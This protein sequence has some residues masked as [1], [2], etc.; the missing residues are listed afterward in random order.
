MVFSFAAVLLAALYLGWQPAMAAMITGAVLSVMLVPSVKALPGPVLSYL[1]T[2]AAL[3]GIAEAFRRA[4]SDARQSQER[5]RAFI[6]NSV[7]GIYRIEFQ[8][9][10][11]TTLPENEVIRL[12]YEHGRLAECNEAFARMYGHASCEDIHGAGLDVMLPRSDPRSIEWVRTI[13]RAGYRIHDAESV[14]RDKHGNEVWVS[15]T[16]EGHL[17]DGRLVRVWG[18]Q[19]ELSERRR[20]EA[21]LRREQAFLRSTIDASP[22]LIFVKDYEGRF[23]LVNSALA[24]LY[25]STPEEMVGKTDADFNPSAEELENFKRADQRVITTLE[26]LAIPE[27]PVTSAGGD[28]RWFSTVKVPLIEPDGS[29]SRVLGVASDITARK[30]AEEQLRKSEERFRAVFNQQY[31]FMAILDPEGRVID[32]NDLPLRVAGGDR[33]DIVGRPFWDTIWWRDLPEERAQWRARL[34]EA[35]ATDG[36]V[37]RADRYQTGSGEIRLA[38]AAIT[39]IKDASGAVEF[40]IVQA[41]DTTDRREAERNLQESEERFRTLADNMSQFCWM[42]DASGWIFWYNRRWYEYTGTTL[43]E[44]QGWGWRSVHHPDHVDRVVAHYQ[45]AFAA[46]EDWEDTFPLRSASGEYRWFLSRAVP[47]RDERGQITR[48]FGTNTDIT[49]QMRTQEELERLTDD[50]RHANADLLQF[51]SIASHDLK[52]PLRGIAH[53]AAFV[54]EDERDRLGP[55]TVQRLE[56]M[57]TLCTRLSEMVDGL[58]LYSRTGLEA[59]MQP[60]PLDEVVAHVIDTCAEDLASQNASVVI[61]GSLPV[62]NGDRLLLERVFANLIANGIKFNESAEKRVEVSAAD[63]AVLVRDNGI[64]IEPRHHETIF[65]VFRR[66]NPVDKYAGTGL[67]LAL[68]KRIVERHGGRVELESAPGRGSTFRLYFPSATPAAAA[69]DERSLAAPGA[70]SRFRADAFQ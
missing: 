1:F 16:L 35:A 6:A 3:I 10:V 51:A 47:I 44:V 23:V 20:S 60:C 30:K 31:Q 66:A 14:E 15:N 24:D 7:E 12:C 48:W 36:P 56:R 13:I 65:R 8:P 37:F 46:G 39:A 50:L 40:Y 28:L 45:E 25:G 64:G 59:H 61:R 9:P 19:R 4:A 27:E 55:A 54:Q 21:A 52:E 68:V 5:Y 26:P 18:A 69:Q 22:S 42:A 38:D 33:A 53:L 63:G 62:V 34:R 67:G 11:D 41:S 49:E 2:G 58:L 17:E 32:V 43:Q 70:G 57:R 29:C